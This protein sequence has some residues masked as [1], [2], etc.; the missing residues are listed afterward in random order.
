[1]SSLHQG[2]LY[3]SRA[4]RQVVFKCY[5]ISFVIIFN[6]Y[7]VGKNQTFAAKNVDIPV[8]YW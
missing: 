2:A 5:H 4:W 7:V 3:S 6:V 8:Q 1:M